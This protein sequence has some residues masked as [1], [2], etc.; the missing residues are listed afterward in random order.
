MYPFSPKLPYHPGWR[1]V[2]K[3]MS[4]TLGT[5]LL[6]PANQV[7]WLWLHLLHSQVSSQKQPDFG[8]LPT[9]SSS[10]TDG[11]TKTSKVASSHLTSVC[12]EDKSPNSAQHTFLS[13]IF[14]LCTKTKVCGTLN[15][16]DMRSGHGKLKP[17]VIKPHYFPLHHLSQR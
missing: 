8:N 14:S 7:W 1:Q 16:P 6:L 11:Q 5:R 17:R 10:C 9:Q 13:P 3:S 12:R 15:K 2:F 4:C